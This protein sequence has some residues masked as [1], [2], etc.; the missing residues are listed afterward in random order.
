[1]LLF[2]IQTGFIILISY[3]FVHYFTEV[4]EVLEPMMQSIEQMSPDTLIGTQESLMLY[5][6]LKKVTGIFSL[7]ALVIYLIYAILNGLNWDFTNLFV[8]KKLGFPMYE[9]QFS[10]LAFI[11]LLPAMIVFRIILKSLVQLEFLYPAKIIAGLIV[12]VTWYFML[13]SFALINK[14]KLSQL[15]KH[16]L[17]TFVIG[18]KKAKILI[19]TYAIIIAVI[20][21][22][23][24]LVYL[25]Q[26]SAYLSVT[27][28][29]LIL[30]IIAV[31]WTRIYFLTTMKNLS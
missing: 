2:V 18:Y 3:L 9:I 21:G 6:N 29:S 28:L 16:L 4:V 1:L 26:D 27:F 5:A 24:Y 22:F 7:A 14:Y 8:N 11:F 12:L 19:P 23:L 10:V 31:V 25:L 20:S 13:I 17:Q 30:F 15:K